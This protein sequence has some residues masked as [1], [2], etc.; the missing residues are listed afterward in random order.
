MKRDDGVFS[1]ISSYGGDVV[2]AGKGGGHP[3][4][5]GDLTGLVEVV[6]LV[7]G[8]GER[9]PATEGVVADVVEVVFGGCGEEV[10]ELEVVETAFVVEICVAEFVKV[11]DSGWIVGLE[12]QE[13]FKGKGEKV[14][15]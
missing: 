13:L 14:R 2:G 9:V 7:G 6:D 3:S 4:F 11:V 5:P 1:G 10:A 12:C 15:G 8:V